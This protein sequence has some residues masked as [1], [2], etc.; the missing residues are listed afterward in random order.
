MIRSSEIEASMSGPL[1][2]VVLMEFGA[3]VSG[4][5]MHRSWLVS[6]EVDSA[7]I[8]FGGG[9]GVELSEQ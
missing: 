2:G 9:T 3:V 4:D 1:D 5:S 6:D 8:D 7:A